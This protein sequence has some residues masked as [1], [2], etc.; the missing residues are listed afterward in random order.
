MEPV[1]KID[2]LER[3]FDLLLVLLGIIT[4]ALFQF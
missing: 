2:E 3:I 1:E 4:A